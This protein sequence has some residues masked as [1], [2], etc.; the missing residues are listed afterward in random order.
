MLAG[1]AKNQETVSRDDVFL[2]SFSYLTQNHIDRLV[3]G[4]NTPILINWRLFYSTYIQDT[5]IFFAKVLGSMV[6]L[7]LTLHAVINREVNLISVFFIG[8]FVYVL[9]S[10]LIYFGMALLGRVVVG[11]IPYA[12]MSQH[13]EIERQKFGFNWFLVHSNRSTILLEFEFTDPDTD[14][15]KSQRVTTQLTHISHVPSQGQPILVLKFKN[16]YRVL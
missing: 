3:K 12:T 2:L 15:I 13:R 4:D 1:K 11:H 9:G 8:V 5:Y 6:G 16:F 10:L 7:F 14:E